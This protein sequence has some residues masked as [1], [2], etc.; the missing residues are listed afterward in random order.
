[1]T[2]HEFETEEEMDEEFDRICELNDEHL[3]LK[4][5]VESARSD[6]ETAKEELKTAEEELEE[7]EKELDEFEKRNKKYL[8]GA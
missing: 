2:I 6:V 7:A 4:E 3:L 8:L 5:G 1:M